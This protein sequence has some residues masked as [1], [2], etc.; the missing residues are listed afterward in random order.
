MFGKLPTGYREADCCYTCQHGRGSGV[1]PGWYC[2]FFEG[3]SR[4][5]AK[6][7]VCDEWGRVE[8]ESTDDYLDYLADLQRHARRD[9][10]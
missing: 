3:S 7:F 9:E 8:E 4:S 6:H 5:V 2:S 1:N 10:E